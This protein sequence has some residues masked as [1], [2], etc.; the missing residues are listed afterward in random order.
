MIFPREIVTSRQVS[1]HYDDLDALYREIWGEHLHHGLWTTGRESA[2][3]AVVALVAR[4]ADAAAIRPG[5]RVCD[6]GCG[7][8]ATSRWLAENR[9]ARVTGL[10]ISERQHAH[11]DD[12]QNLCQRRFSRELRP[13]LERADAC[14]VPTD[15]PTRACRGGGPRDAGKHPLLVG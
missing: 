8:G 1:G 2:E 10:T 13:T 15:Y 4:V 9:G 7:Y 3:A 14:A 6:V 12:E 11:G 5:D